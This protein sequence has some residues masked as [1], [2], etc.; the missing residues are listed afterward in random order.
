MGCVLKRENNRYAWRYPAA[1]VRVTPHLQ[2][3]SAGA[4]N[5]GHYY[6]NVRMALLA[7]V[8]FLNSVW[9]TVYS[10]MNVVPNETSD[11][12]LEA[13]VEEETRVGIPPHRQPW[14]GWPDFLM[15]KRMASKIRE[16]TDTLAAKK[17]TNRSLLSPLH[18]RCV[19]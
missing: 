18:A 10:L 17:K 12:A 16:K 8:A 11:Q 1:V 19:F 3:D 14:C 4:K 2:F 9:E 5:A 15:S 6:S 7:Y 13:F